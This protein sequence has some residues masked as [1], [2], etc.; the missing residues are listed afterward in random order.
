MVGGVQDGLFESTL[1]TSPFMG[2]VGTVHSFFFARDFSCPSGMDRFEEERK[3]ETSARGR[4]FS[5]SA[6]RLLRVSS[7]L[8]EGGNTAHIAFF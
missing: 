8:E 2:V 5:L 1:S 3:M 4:C 6:Q 7:L